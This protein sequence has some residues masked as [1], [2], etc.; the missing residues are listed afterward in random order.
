[1]RRELKS[2]QIEI[3]KPL[4]LEVDKV[5]TESGLYSDNIEFVTDAVR[6]LIL[7]SKEGDMNIFSQGKSEE[8]RNN[9]DIDKTSIKRNLPHTP[10]LK[11]D[12]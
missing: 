12:I 11:G 6:R 1:V 7:E 4:I 9:L 3:P 5:V 2:L 8:L 10:S